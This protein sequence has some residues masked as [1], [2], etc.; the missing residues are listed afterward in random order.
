MYN[1]SPPIFKKIIGNVR[2]DIFGLLFSKKVPN[3]RLKAPEKSF[4]GPKNIYR[5]LLDPQGS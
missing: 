3:K 2:K 4:G 5:V 1:I